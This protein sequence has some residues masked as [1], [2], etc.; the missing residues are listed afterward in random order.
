MKRKDGSCKFAYAFGMFPYPKTGERSVSGWVYFVFPI[1]TTTSA[2][3]RRL[4]RHSRLS[5]QDRMKLAVVFDKVI[6]VP[7]YLSL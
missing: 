2:S 7:L 3:R 1:E 4:F 5:L 6:L